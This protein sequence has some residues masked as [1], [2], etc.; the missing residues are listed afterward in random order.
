MFAIVNAVVESVA[1]PALAGATVLVRD[2]RIATVGRKVRVPASARRIDAAG[3]TLT[4][5]FIDAHTHAGLV[6]DGLPGDVDYNERTDP[7]TPHV[8]AIDAF[9]PTDASLLEAAQSGVTAAFV[10]PGSANVIGGLG[11]VVKTVAPSL[12]AQVVR[13][14]AGLKMATGENPKRVYGEQKKMPSTRM[15]AA[16]VMRQALT[17]AQAYVERKRRHRRRKAAKDLFEI[18]LSM[19][20]LVGLLRGRYPARCH[21]H[22]STDMLTAMR[23]AD[24]FGFR[25]VFEHATEC[26]DILPDLA[27]RKIPVVIGPTLGSRSK[28]EVQ[29]KRFATVAAAVAA[30]LTVAIT[31]DTD[32]TP[33]RY[34]NVYAALAIREG[35]AP[36]DALRCL[37]VNPA[38]ICGVAD[39]LGTIERGK[40]ADLVLWDGDPFDARTRPAAVWIDGQPVDMTIEPFTSW[41]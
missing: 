41:R 4:P 37:T 21:A 3:R 7:V 10:T 26:E 8:R 14:D 17:K 32:V 33:L 35:L 19:E 16:A 23:I 24:E 5:G 39:R 12:D 9:R 29:R 40:D 25:L 34:L 31:A 22:R 1:R 18:D 15:G 2:G 11:A 20:S 38:T 27:A 6:E 36:A 28:I 30:G 13:H